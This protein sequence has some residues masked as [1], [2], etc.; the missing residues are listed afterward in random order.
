VISAKLL[1]DGEHV[2]VSTRTHP[3]ALVIPVLA[4]L[5]VLAGAGFVSS[6]DVG[7]SGGIL[8]IVTWALAALLIGWFSA[9][10][11]LNWLTTTYTFTNRR[12]MKR[13]GILSRV[14]RTIPL[15]RISGVDFEQGVVD[16]VFRC[17]TLVV[18]DASAN[19][20]V[21]LTDVPR[22]ERVQL[23]VA[24]ELHRLSGGDSEARDGGS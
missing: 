14:G 4:L 1:N 18:T 9:R 22:V 8:F 19:G 2:V 6:L 15:N 5:L 16:R 21:E 7:A 20:R 3:K 11:L 23:L 12:F 13:S 24:E 17:G 10:P